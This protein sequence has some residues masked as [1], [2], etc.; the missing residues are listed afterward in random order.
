MEFEKAKEIRD[1][2]DI[3]KSI[4]VEQNIY[5]N[6]NDDMDILGIY[7]ENGNYIIVILSVKDGKL[8][9]RKDFFIK[10]PSI[11]KFKK[12][13]ELKGLAKYSDIVSAF[14]T[15][16]YIYSFYWICAIANHFS[17]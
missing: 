4:N 5:I 12:L 8:A 1:K 14:F 15:Q 6:E 10:A 13:E 7:G 11:N 9:D 17:I 2:I 3:L 16:Y